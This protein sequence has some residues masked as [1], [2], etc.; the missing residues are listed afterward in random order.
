[1]SNILDRLN[2]RFKTL[3]EQED[4]AAI[5]LDIP[6]APEKDELGGADVTGISSPDTPAVIAREDLAKVLGDI[7]RLT[8][9]KEQKCRIL[10][11][12]LPENSEVRQAMDAMAK[13]ELGQWKVINKYVQQGLK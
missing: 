4:P 2:Q 12:Q 11:L 6:D 1:M 10:A 7:E 8:L 5:N 3:T 13:S 9:E